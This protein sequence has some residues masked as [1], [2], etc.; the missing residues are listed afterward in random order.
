MVYNDMNASQ[1]FIDN[2]ATGLT[3]GATYVVRVETS[4]GCF[5]DETIVIPTAITSP[6][7][8]VVADPLI[9]GEFGSFTITLIGANMGQSLDDFLVEYSPGGVFDE[10]TAIEVMGNQVTG[11]MAGTYS[12]RLT[13][14]EGCTSEMSVIIDELYVTPTFSVEVIQATCNTPTGGFIVDNIVAPN[15]FIISYSPGSPYNEMTGIDLLPG[16]TMVDNL[17]AGT[18]SVQ[19]RDLLTDCPSDPPII[20]IGDDCMDIPTM[21]QWTLFILGLLMTSLAVVYIRRRANA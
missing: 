14:I 11:L 21:S 18:Y 4:F 20:I 8:E 9:C 19:M 5:T 7:F 15:G 6:E 12:V 16:E 13:D 3:P 2:M 10:M 17:E 1:E